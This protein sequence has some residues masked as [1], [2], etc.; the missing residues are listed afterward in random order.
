MTGRKFV[1]PRRA[2][3][4]TA[5]TKTCWPFQRMIMLCIATTGWSVAS[6]R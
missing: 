5:R 6:D 3:S 4:A 2:S 1:T